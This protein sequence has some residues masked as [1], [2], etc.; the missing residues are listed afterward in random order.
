MKKVLIMLLCL[1]LIT[2]CGAKNNDKELEALKEEVNSL[3]QKID[4]QTTDTPI[5]ENIENASLDEL[6]QMLEENKKE[7]ESLSKDKKTLEEKVKQLQD[8]NSSLD[9][10][11]TSL[12][13]SNK[14]LK[15]TINSL[16]TSSS[17]KTTNQ[18]TITKKQLIGTWT[19]DG[20]NLVF[21]NSNCDV[22]GNWIIYHQNGYDS[23]LYY[24][25]KDGKLYITDDG[26]VY[27][28]K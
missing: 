6:K 10:K 14:S 8:S 5:D 17:S 15:S 22:I 27:S 19:V 4:E 20:H 24:M 28:K 12:E 3:K 1:M 23:T 2:G 18:Y 21:S 11:V 26:V 7:I 25:Y 13:S 9:K 16:S